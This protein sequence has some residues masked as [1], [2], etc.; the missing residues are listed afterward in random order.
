MLRISLLKLM[1]RVQYNTRLL[2]STQFFREKQ[3][4]KPFSLYINVS[5]YFAVPNKLC[6]KN[7]NEKCTSILRT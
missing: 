7:K 3:R 5:Y 6:S 2:Y 4:R 1:V